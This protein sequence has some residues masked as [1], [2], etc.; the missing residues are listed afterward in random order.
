MQFKSI[1][2]PNENFTVR[3]EHLVLDINDL[4]ACPLTRID[5]LF[6]LVEGGSAIRNGPF[7]RVL[8]VCPLFLFFRLHDSSLV[9]K[10]ELVDDSSDASVIPPVVAP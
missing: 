9:V 6:D 3:V 8:F 1:R 4:C 10:Y 2:P 5:R 7:P